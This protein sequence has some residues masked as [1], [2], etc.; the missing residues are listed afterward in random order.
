MTGVWEVWNEEGLCIA[1]LWINLIRCREKE[2]ETED[3]V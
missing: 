3:H 1:N 2:E